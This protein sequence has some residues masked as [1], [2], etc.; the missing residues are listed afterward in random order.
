MA[1]A[2]AVGLLLISM[3]LRPA[4]ISEVPAQTFDIRLTVLPDEKGA[5]ILYRAYTPVEDIALAFPATVIDRLEIGEGKGRVGLR[6]DGD[7]V[8]LTADEEFGLA[9]LIVDFSETK[10]DNPAVWSGSGAGVLNMTYFTPVRVNDQLV[11]NKAEALKVFEWVGGGSSFDNDRMQILTDPGMPSPVISMLA[12]VADQ[13]AGHM[14]S[15]FGRELEVKPQLMFLY[16]EG[17]EGQLSVSG[18]AT[19]GQ[20]VIRYE[21][22]G[23]REGTPEMQRLVMFNLAHEMVHLWQLEEAKVSTTSDWLHEGIADALAAEALFVAG[24]WGEEVYFQTLNEARDACAGYLGTG[25]LRGASSRGHYGA[26]YS[27][28]HMVAAALSSQKQGETISSMWRA[29]AE[30]AREQPGGFSDE[31]FYEFAENWTGSDTF[32]RS[33]RSFVK[34]DYRSANHEKIIDRL[35]AGML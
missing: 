9:G 3:L 4:S 29:F 14:V 2:V 17:M 19:R 26:G 21:G 15:A 24:I 6:F 7:G 32:V 13:L 33:M 31:T 22:G 16:A 35:F 27:C 5:E 25:T 10:V 34:S 18:E 12:P 20:S 23:F 30:F 8:A 11:S 28:G 1:G